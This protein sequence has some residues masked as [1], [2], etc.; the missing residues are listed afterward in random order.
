MKFFAHRGIVRRV[1]LLEAQLEIAG[2]KKQLADAHA[3]IADRD[4]KIAKLAA[5]VATLQAAVKQLL[6]HRGGGHGDQEGQGLLFPAAVMTIE[7]SQSD[8][9]EH[10]DEEV[11]DGSRPARSERGRKRTPGKI[12]TTGLPHDILHVERDARPNGGLAEAARLPS[13]FLPAVG[14]LAQRFRVNRFNRS[15]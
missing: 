2:L 1:T 13:E 14:C 12:D 4:A 15:A 7:A 11:D 6:R 9:G 5:D 10:V 3:A 8:A